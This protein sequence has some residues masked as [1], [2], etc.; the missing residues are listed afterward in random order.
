MNNQ[1]L[2]FDELA[3]KLNIKKKED[4]YQVSFLGSKLMG[5]V[6]LSDVI[7][8]GG[9][10]IMTTYFQNSLVKALSTI[11]PGFHN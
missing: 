3:K 11:Y 1:R 8:Y 9:G 2:F 10:S 5:K 6:K 7:S 4:W